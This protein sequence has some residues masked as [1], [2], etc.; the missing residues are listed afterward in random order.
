[1]V[2]RS[3]IVLDIEGLPRPPSLDFDDGASLAAYARDRPPGAFKSAACVWQ[4]SGSS[5]HASRL[6]EIRIHL[7]FMLD[8]PVFPGGWKSFFRGIQIV[9]LSAFDKAKLIFTV[10]PSVENGDYP[11]T[12]R[13]GVIDGDPRVIIP[14]ATIAQSAHIANGAETST[15]PPLVAPIAPMPRGA[16]VRVRS[17]PRTDRRWRFSLP[18]LARPC[19]HGRSH[20][21]AERRDGRPRARAEGDASGLVVMTPA[22]ANSGQAAKRL[23]AA[24][25]GASLPL[26]ASVLSIV[27]NL[28][29]LDLNGLR[30][31]W[32]AHLGGEA[33]AHLSRW[34]LMKVLAYR[35]QSDAF[36]DLDKSI[37]RILRSGKED[38]VG[39]PFDRRAPQTRDGVDLKVGALLVREWKGKLERVMILEEG[40]A[41]NGQTFGSLSQTAKAM[42]GTSWNGHR[43]F[44]LRQGKTPAADVG[45][46]R[47]KSRNRAAVCRAN[48]ASAGDASP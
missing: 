14:M 32:R 47:R 16:Q 31:Q 38:G 1:V 27:A 43:F 20:H 8:A 28:E 33:P 2:P 25:P 48:G 37:R 5:G 18:D 29:G 42:T 9:D 13:H 23:V 26:D 39:A 46:D 35:L 19:S 7:F 41:W 11:T 15:R 4:L 17:D 34:L 22:R 40:F 30:R 10:A 45:A 36:G 6:D 44:G 3:W 12:P 24:T 21:T